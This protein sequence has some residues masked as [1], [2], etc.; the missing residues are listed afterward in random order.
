MI[1]SQRSGPSDIYVFL[2]SMLRLDRSAQGISVS[3]VPHVCIVHIAQWTWP[4]THVCIVHIAQWA[5]PDTHVS[6]VHIA[7]WA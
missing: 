5:W 1:I 7:Q 6:I 2:Q 3:H 4:D